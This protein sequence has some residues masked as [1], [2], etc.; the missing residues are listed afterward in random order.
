MEHKNNLGYLL[1]KASRLTKWELT[2]VLMEVGITAAQFGLIK[3]IYINE[4]Q[5]QDEEE[6]LQRLTPAAIAERLHADR[7]TVSCM[8]EKLVKQDWAY[9]VSNPKD[10]RSQIIL[11]TVKAREM[12]PKLQLLGETTMDKAVKDFDEQETAQLKQ[13]LMRIIE[14]LSQ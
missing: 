7:P 4:M 12:M 8:I 1:S 5:C 13:Y 3:D 14:N 2:N 9:R 6:K 10:R 11:L